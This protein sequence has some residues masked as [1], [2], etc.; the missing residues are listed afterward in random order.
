MVIGNNVASIIS[1]FQ[2]CFICVCDLNFIYF[3]YNFFSCGVSKI[4]HKN[5]KINELKLQDLSFIVIHCEIWRKYKL[6]AFFSF[7]NKV[8]KGLCLRVVK[9]W[10]DAVKSK[11]LLRCS[12]SDEDTN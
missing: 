5:T 11:D 9:T 4:L 1:L 10:D 12:D 6:P 2:P 8:L 3:K 7:T